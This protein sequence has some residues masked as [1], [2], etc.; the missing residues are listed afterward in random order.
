MTA[1]SPAGGA[2]LGGDRNF[3]RWGLARS[4]RSLGD[5][6]LKVIPG[7]QFPSP[8][9]LPG[10][11]GVNCYPSLTETDQNKSTPLNCLVWYFV[12]AKK[13]DQ[14]RLLIFFLFALEK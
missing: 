9:L 12:I 6:L 2:I 1:L 3:R 4:S 10:H 5:E 8:S 14:H 13:Y 11:H 7:S